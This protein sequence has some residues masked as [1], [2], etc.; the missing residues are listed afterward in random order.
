MG[1]CVRECVRAC[2]CV[3]LCVC[4]RENIN[5]FSDSRCLFYRIEFGC[6][7]MVTIPAEDPD[8]DI[9]RCRWANPDECGQACTNTPDKALRLSKVHLYMIIINTI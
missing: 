7:T 1:V 2:V 8:S 5:K 4:E 9:V 3:Y 6:S